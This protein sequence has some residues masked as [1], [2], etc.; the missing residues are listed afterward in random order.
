MRVEPLLRVT[1]HV[2]EAI[3]VEVP[4]RTDEKTGQNFAA[5]SYV[6]VAV[7]VAGSLQGQVLDGV[8]VPMIVTDGV[9]GELA[10]TSP[11]TLVDIFVYGYSTWQRHR[12]R[13]FTVAR[14]RFVATVPATNANRSA[15]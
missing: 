13:S 12:G 9:G 5:Y 8:A 4:E 11:G 6:E 2:K 3:K 14:H 15:A 10:K 7:E 1:G